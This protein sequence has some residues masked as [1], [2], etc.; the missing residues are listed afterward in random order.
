MSRNVL[1]AVVVLALV[2]GGWYLMRPK[3]T[4]TP[5]YTQPTETPVG[6]Q[7]ATPTA[8]EGA[9]MTD[10]TE[11]KVSGSEFKFTPDTL[12]VKKGDKVKIVFQNDGKFPHDLKIDELGVTT[13]VINPGQS[14]S[15]EF[16]VG[17]SGTFTMYCSVDAHRQKG[18]E[19]T[20]TAL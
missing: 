7:S 13:K 3:T 18:M 8:T 1:I 2:A 5:S 19:G 12:S 15:V 17:K 9:M 16:T 20:V 10:V 6:T 4:M 11:I 14:D